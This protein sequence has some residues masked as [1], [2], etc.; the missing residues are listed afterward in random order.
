MST[1]LNWPTWAAYCFTTLNTDSLQKR[2]PLHSGR[3]AVPHSPETS[4]ICPCNTDIAREAKTTFIQ[5]V[6]LWLR[7]LE[8]ETDDGREEEIKRV[9]D[10]NITSFGLKDSPNGS[11]YSDLQRGQ[12]TEIRW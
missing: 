6:G 4:A 7:G 9:L 8:Q 12:D 5:T 1:L 3:Q 10:L 11:G 2:F